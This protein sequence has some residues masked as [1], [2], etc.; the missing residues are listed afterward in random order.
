V[1]LLTDRNRLAGILRERL[2]TLAAAFGESI[3]PSAKNSISFAMTLSSLDKATQFANSQLESNAVVTSATPTQLGS[4]LFYRNVSGCRVIKQ[5]SKSSK[6][7]PHTFGNWGAHADVH[8]ASYLTAAAAIGL[9]EPEI[10][11]FIAR[12]EKC[13]KQLLRKNLVSAVAEVAVNAT[14]MDSSSAGCEKK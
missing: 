7:G 9:T 6:I 3:I 11:L 2:F 10:D 13:L 8:S 12:L 1:K 14:Q 5:G 4:Q